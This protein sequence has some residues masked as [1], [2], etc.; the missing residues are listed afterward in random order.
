[1]YSIKGE[2]IKEISQLEISTI[3]VSDL[4]SG[5]YVLSLFNENEFLASKR[6][7]IE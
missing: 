6:I 2:I 3:N 7:V 5:V 4:K 1:V